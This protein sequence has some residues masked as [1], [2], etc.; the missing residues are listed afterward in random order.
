ML[1]SPIKIA[2]LELSNRI[3]VAPMCQY[4]AV[5]GVMTDWHTQHLMQLGYSGAGLVMIEAT[6]VERIGRITHHCT[7]IYNDFCEL[8]IKKILDQAKSV[9]SKKTSFGIQLAHA[10]RKAS[11]QRPWEGRK[12]LTEEE[13]PWRTA[14]PSSL[15]FDQGWHFQIILKT[16]TWK[17]SRTSLWKLHLDQSKL[18]LI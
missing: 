2:D 4:S 18:D 5:D 9:S 17:G 12:S 16:K 6:A 8:S 15:A 13:N 10:G 1:F 7:G 14:G 11:T 3:A